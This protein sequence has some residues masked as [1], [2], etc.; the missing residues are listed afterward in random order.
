MR[1][2]F[3]DS[4][5]FHAVDSIFRSNARDPWATRLAG[6]LADAFIYNDQLRYP[7]PIPGP[8]GGFDVATFDGLLRDLTLRDSGFF[9]GATYPNVEPRLLANE[10]LETCFNDFSAWAR[11]NVVSL[12]KWLSSH[13]EPWVQ[14]FRRA[15]SG[16]AHTFAV[17]GLIKSQSLRGLSHELG[18][19]PDDLLYCFDSV[20]KFP[21]F[22]EL[23]EADERYLSHPIRDAFLLPTMSPERGTLPFMAVTFAESISLFADRLSRDEYTTLLHELRGAVRDK[24]LHKVKPADADKEVVREL[25]SRVNLPPR[26]SGLGKA[27]GITGGVLCG[28]GALTPLAAGAAIAGAVVTISTSIWTGTLPRSVAKVRWLRW[29]LRW[30]IERQL[31]LR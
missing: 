22:G 3:I 27:A 23:A 1:S 25:A 11:A 30:D 20:L 6:Q 29:A 18:I 31:E 16:G 2:T 28:L 13:H 19:P 14:A 24:G 10:Y 21:L 7:V 17:E 9:R 4:T 5:T 12:R 15:T 8:G 26:I